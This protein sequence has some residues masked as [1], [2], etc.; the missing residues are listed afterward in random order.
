MLVATMTAF[1]FTSCEDVPAAYE[2]PG[3]GNGGNGGSTTEVPTLYSE[4]FDNNTTAFEFK[5]VNLTGGLTRVW[6]VVSYNNNGYLN[7]SAFLNNAS[8]ASESWAVSPAINLADSK[9]AVLAFSH[10]INK[11][12]D[13]STMKDMMTVWA[14]TD[15]TGDVSTATWKQLVVPNYPAGTSWT[16]VE[17]GDIDLTEYCGNKVYIGFKYTSTDNNSGGWEVDNFTIK[18]DGTPMV[19]PGKP[20][21]PDT[22]DTPAGSNLVS[23]GDFEAWTNSLP[24][25]WKSASSASNAK[26]SQST[27]A[28][29]GQY[30]VCVAGGAKNQRLA[31]KEL[32][33]KPGT[34]KMSFYTKAATADG[35]VVDYGY[36]KV[37][38]GKISGGND[39]IYAKKYDKLTNTEW[40]AIS[41]EFTLAEKTTVALIIAVIKNP[42]KD[43]LVDDFSLTTADGGVVDG[44]STE[45]DQPE[46]STASTYTLVN[47][48]TDGTY[49]LVAKTDAGYLAASPLAATY[50]YGYLKN[51]VSVTE[52]NGTVKVSDANA[53]TIKKVD[54]GYTIQDATGYYF[55]NGAY[56]SFSRSAELPASG[57]IW[58]I[59]VNSDKTVSIKNN[60]MGKTIQ[61][62]TEFTSFGA[63]E[64]IKA[65]LPFLYKK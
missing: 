22:P 36:V 63:Y 64:E 41:H 56:N 37:V 61:Y 16:F 1:T 55:M 43:L 27:D 42:G 10:A 20:D 32:T 2:I 3:G 11:L 29:S 12:S 35:A 18:G 30:S 26:L 25:N 46:T 52:S 57:H 38:D 49:V 60:E 31:Y 6:K 58:T 47:Q 9:K 33:L 24:N 40:T 15:Y 45:P 39:Y 23:N 51:P 5:D 54:G 62:D 59:T 34:Y 8:H 28:H 53:F 17:S 21:T 50:N 19:T 65:I 44:G 4:A 7:A 14:S 48:I 13:V